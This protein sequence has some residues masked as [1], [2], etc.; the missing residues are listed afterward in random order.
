MHNILNI[1][2][3]CKKPTRQNFLKKNTMPMIALSILFCLACCSSVDHVFLKSG[4]HENEQKTLK[5]IVLATNPGSFTKND[6]SGLLIVVARDFLSVQ[7]NYIIYSPNKNFKKNSSW[8]EHCKVNKKLNGVLVHSIQLLGHVD[9]NTSLGVQATLYDCHSGEIVWQAY[10]QDKYKSIDPGLKNVIAS[11][12]NR[13]SPN[14]KFMAGPAY[15][16]IRDLF[17][18]LPEPVLTEK[19]KDEKIDLME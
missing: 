15:L 10:A 11:Y 6:V 2:Q 5:R 18:S 7:K 4:Y 14:F 12:S 13:V 3:R 16:L 1:Y 19:E 9:S 8:R 17:E